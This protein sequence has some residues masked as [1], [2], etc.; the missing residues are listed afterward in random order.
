ML[1]IH[2][3]SLHNLGITAMAFL[4]IAHRMTFIVIVHHE[5]SGSYI[6]RMVCARIATFYMDIHTDLVYSNT[7][8][9][10]TCYYWSLVIA[11]KHL[12]NATSDDFVKFLLC[13][14]LPR[15]T[16][17]WASCLGKTMHGVLPYVITK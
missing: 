1:N 6:L 2:H 7:R 16:N 5:V 8:Y 11:K 9:D 15:P 17:W 3:L 4:S 12:A 10:V 14:I 13:S